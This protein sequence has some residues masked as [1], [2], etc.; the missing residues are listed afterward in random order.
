MN[1]RRVWIVARKELLDS[2]R[3]RRQLIAI[4]VSTLMTPLLLSFMFGRMAEERRGADEIKVPLVGREYA[5]VLV[6][7]LEQQAGIQVAPGPEDAETAV[8]ERKQD[9]VMV[10]PKN[11]SERF[12]ESRP[13]NVKLVSD[14]T[15]TRGRPKVERV[16]NLLQRYGGETGG[17]RL[18]ARGVSPSLASAVTVENVE[19]SS[20]QQRAA[21]IFNMI[22]M[23]VAMSAFFTAMAITT[24]ATA[25]ERER[26][27][28]EPLLVNPVLRFELV[29]GK[30]LAA[31]LSSAGG[32]L[33]TLS[34][35]TGVLLRVPMQDLGLRFSF[36][37]PEALQLVVALM[38]MSVVA[39]AMQM[40]LFT[41]A[42]SRKR[43]AT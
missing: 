42:R 32:M 26:G 35:V 10:I 20:A 30:W 6:D 14:S 7:W 13:A 9:F 2:F 16:R 31:A 27:S 1:L 11:F 38:P 21:I 29:A 12:R 25:G 17:L 43:K 41:F 33:V 23:L 4:T 15:A 34:V 19:V 18:I 22:P 28:L 39:P 24:N 36:G 8:R 5:P 37:V 40:F 3:D